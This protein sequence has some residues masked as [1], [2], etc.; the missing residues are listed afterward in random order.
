MSFRKTFALLLASMVSFAAVPAFADDAAPATGVKAEML[1]FLGDAESKLGDLAEA[2]PAGKYSW[3]PGKGVRSV[4]EVFMHVAAA[5]YGIPAMMGV[6]PPAGFDFE[7]YE[8]SLTKKEDIQKALKDSFASMKQGLVNMSDADMEKPV[9][10]FGMKLT[11][12]GG[13]MLILSHCHEHLGQ[14]IAYARTNGVVPPW[15]AR[16][17]AAEKEKDK[18]K[19]KH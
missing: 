12:R 17:Q 8:A 11:Q 6:T 10:I 5:N 3:R 15:T 18:D 4:A 16:Q 19:D 9:E 7:K 14:S 2:M 1:Q 13:Y